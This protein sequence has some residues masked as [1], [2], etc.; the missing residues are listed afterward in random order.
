MGFRVKNPNPNIINQIIL[1]YII[2]VLSTINKNI[3][4]IMDITL[5]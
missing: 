4:K 1:Y 2:L 5:N 3:C